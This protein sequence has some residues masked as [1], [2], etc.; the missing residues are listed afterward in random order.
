[1][2]NLMCAEVHVHVGPFFNFHTV[3][4]LALTKGSKTSVNSFSPV[5]LSCFE[6]SYPQILMDQEI[7]L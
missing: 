2:F 4:S 5:V 3:L 1:M 7:M 6:A